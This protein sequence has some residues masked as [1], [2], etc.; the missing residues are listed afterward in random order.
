[1]GGLDVLRQLRQKN[2][3]VRIII[4]ST[5]TERGAATTMEALWL[6]ADDYVTK[7]SN[8]GSL[9][10]SMI[11]L[12]GELI[13]KVIQFFEFTGGLALAAPWPAGGLA[14]CRFCWVAG[15]TPAC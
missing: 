14:G 13:P 10:L 6:G 9:D 15:Q 8:S 1:M 3:D 11:A 7:A 2:K 12:R 4:F 5:L